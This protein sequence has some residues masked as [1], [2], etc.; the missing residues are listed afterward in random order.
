MHVVCRKELLSFVRT[1][2]VS[3]HLYDLQEIVNDICKTVVVLTQLCDFAGKS[4]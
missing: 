2:I 4:S 1:G 3:T